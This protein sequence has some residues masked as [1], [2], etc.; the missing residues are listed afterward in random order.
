MN[1]WKSGDN[2]LPRGYTTERAVGIA[3]LVEAQRR[4]RKHRNRIDIQWIRGHDGHLLNEGADALAKLARRYRLPG[5]G[6][7]ESEY[8]RRA[9]GLA[10]SFASAFA[11]Q[12]H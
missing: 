8:H 3:G 2:A 4:V 10:D 6:L 7:T 9:E 1:R 5:S 11:G 12:T